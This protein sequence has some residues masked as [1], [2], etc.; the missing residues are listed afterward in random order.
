MR[1]NHCL[2]YPPCL[3]GFKPVQVRFCSPLGLFTSTDLP[4]PG[5]NTES[6]VFFVLRKIFLQHFRLYHTCEIMGK[7][8]TGQ[9]RE[10]RSPTDGISGSAGALGVRVDRRRLLTMGGGTSGDNEGLRISLSTFSISCLHQSFSRICSHVTRVFSSGF[11]IW[12]IRSRHSKEQGQV[13]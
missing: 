1:T 5:L 7:D 4:L 12:R 10:I 2:P 9:L 3:T 13:L 11:S 6:F 8:N